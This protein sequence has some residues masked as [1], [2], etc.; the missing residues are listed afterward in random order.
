MKALAMCERQSRKDAFDIYFCLRHGRI[1]EIAANLR[2][3]RSNG[4]VQESLRHLADKFA[5]IDHVG[6]TDAAA[7][8]AGNGEEP[9]QAR[10]SAFELTRMLVEQLRG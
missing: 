5:S 1:D 4:L 10:R 6:P 2:Q 3:F 7:V 9:E 8:A